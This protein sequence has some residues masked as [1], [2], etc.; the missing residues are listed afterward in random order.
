MINQAK[1]YEKEEEKFN[2][3]LKNQTLYKLFM[4]DELF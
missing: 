4:R 3:G 2:Q 1:K